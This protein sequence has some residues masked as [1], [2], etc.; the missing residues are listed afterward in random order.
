MLNDSDS[1]HNALQKLLAWQALSETQEVLQHLKMQAEMADRQIKASPLS[2]R[3]TLNR[4]S[5][6]EQVLPDAGTANNLHHQFIGNFQGLTH[7]ERLLVERKAA[8]EEIIKQ[9]QLEEEASHG[10]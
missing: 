3:V 7:L 5:G 8:L 4:I 10:N 1:P 2:I 6:L 9:Q